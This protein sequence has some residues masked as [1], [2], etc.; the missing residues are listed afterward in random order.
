MSMTS[1]ISFH[2]MTRQ[3]RGSLTT[4]LAHLNKMEI[5]YD[6]LKAIES[7]AEEGWDPELKEW[8]L[9]C[10]DETPEYIRLTEEFNVTI[11]YF[12]RAVR[13][14]LRTFDTKFSCRTEWE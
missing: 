4:Q 7:R 10:Q 9:I 6:R 12:R 13:D 1:K 11:R 8:V 14:H 2:A 5:L 3:L